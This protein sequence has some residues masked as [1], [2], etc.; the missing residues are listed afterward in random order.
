MIGKIM[1]QT[2]LAG[3][4]VFLLFIVML[5]V[6]LIDCVVCSLLHQVYLRQ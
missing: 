5:G 6:L 2:G 1:L 4:E 3:L